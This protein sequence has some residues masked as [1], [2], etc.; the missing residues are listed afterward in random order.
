MTSNAT[1][2]TAPTASDQVTVTV[3]PLPAATITAGGPLAFCTGGSVTLTASAGTSWLWSNGAT[4][5]S[6]TV[7]TAGS[8]SVTVTN[9]A[10]CS[11]TSAETVVIV[12]ALPVATITA[13]GPLAFCSGGSVTLTASAGSSWLWSTGATTQAIT[14]NNAGSYSVTVTNA[15]NCSA[16][17]AATV[18]S[19]N[20]LPA[21]TI[22]AGGP[23][24]FCSGGS[25]TLTASAGASWLW[26][27]GATTQSITV[28]TAGSYS[29]TVTNADGC[30]ATSAATVVT[31]NALP[32]ATITAGGPLAFCTGGSLT[33]T[34]SAGASW[35]W[36]TGATTQSITV[37]IAGSYSVTVTNA[38]NC[39]A[40]SAAMVVTV[41][42][43]VTPAVTISSPSTTV[44]GNSS[45]TF[46]AV[47]NNGGAGPSYQWQVNG[48][49]V[50]TNS[51]T[52]TSSTLNAGDLV[53]V[54][55]T[56]NATC[57]TSPTAIS[58]TITITSNNVTPGVTISPNPATVCTGDNLVFTANPIN[59]GA[60]PSYQWKVNGSNVGTN[61]NTYSSSTLNNA[62][63]V[64]VTMTS[65][66]T[67]IT[68]PTAS[69]QVT[70]TVTPL[71]AATIT[72]GG[73][74]AF[75][76]GGSVTLTAS[77]GSSWLWSTGATTQS[78]TVNTAGSYSVTVTNASQLFSY[79]CSNR[80]NGKCITC[81][82]DHCRWTAGILYRRFCSTD[83]ISRYILVMEYRSNNS[84]YHR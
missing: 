10:N 30:S 58:N 22:T 49:N 1:C 2:I 35:L 31:V 29:V 83:R 15:A 60:A 70:V 69:D 41:T 8:Y 52:Y 71:P 13:G 72:A 79:I 48:S 39:S 81:S 56:S 80:R 26:S 9:A 34:A 20:A 32:A 76:T 59:G 66:A 33:L 62:D 19:V 21:A 78:I 42:P 28:N 12:N 3:N 44:C 63:I 67:C 16:T 47:P 51:N 54:I 27:T 11:A 74:L 68:T 75:C 5:Q 6:I 53:T 40:T 38:S 77:A 84:V 82:N 73:P 25:V 36:N 61:S 55:M 23:L 57:I 24:A 45:I 14:V 65:N 46:T 64:S 4:T 43:G 17:S 7:N 37:N 50:G 18:V